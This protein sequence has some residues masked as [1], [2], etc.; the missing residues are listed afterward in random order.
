MQEVNSA[1]T[2]LSLAALGYADAPGFDNP[3]SAA[4]VFLLAGN[5]KLAYQHRDDLGALVLLPGPTTIR[6]LRNLTPPSS[7]A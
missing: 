4:R 3:E 6:S 7:R 5:Q 1:E 2:A